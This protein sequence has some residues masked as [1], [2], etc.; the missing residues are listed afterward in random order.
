MLRADHSKIV[1]AAYHFPSPQENRQ[2]RWAW[3]VVSTLR[4]C[5]DVRESWP[6]GQAE[7]TSWVYLRNGREREHKHAVRTRTQTRSHSQCDATWKKIDTTMRFFRVKRKWGVA[8]RARVKIVRAQVE[9][10][11]VCMCACAHVR[12][13]HVRMCDSVH[14]RMCV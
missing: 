6:S 1:D 5:R 10:M 11:F 7:R 9:Y 3:Y 4:S 2:T 13:V 14:V 12:S 8:A